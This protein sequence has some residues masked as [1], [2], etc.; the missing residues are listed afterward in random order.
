MGLNYLNSM[1]YTRIPLKILLPVYSARYILATETEARKAI[2]YG[3]K[4]SVDIFM[5]VVAHV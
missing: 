3:R 5:G 1:F 2:K 4:K